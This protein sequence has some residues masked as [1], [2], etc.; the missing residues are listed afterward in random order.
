MMISMIKRINIIYFLIGLA[1]LITNLCFIDIASAQPI[2]KVAVL[3]IQDLT[4]GANG[5]N[6]NCTNMLEQDLSNHGIKTVS[7]KQIMSFLVRHRIRWTGYIDSYDAFMLGKELNTNYVLLGTICQYDNKIEPK[8]G[9]TLVLL[10]TK[11][12]S[13]VWAWVGSLSIKD[14]IHPLGLFE[15]K[16]AANILPFLIDKA[17]RAFPETIEVKG[18]IFPCCSIKNVIIRPR[19]V[20]SGELVTCVVRVNRLN[21]TIKPIIKLYLNNNYIKFR[22]IYRNEYKA[23]FKAPIKQGS[24][25]V[26]LTYQVKKHLHK[27]YVG[28]IVVDN[29]APKVK[30]IARGVHIW[31]AIALK[32]RL[33]ILPR[34]TNPEPI[35][36]WQIAVCT[37]DGEKILSQDGP[38]PL[39][40]RF[41][42][43]GQ[44]ASGA[45]V[46]TGV[47]KIV[48]DIWDMAGNKAQATIKVAVIRT[49]PQIKVSSKFIHNKLILTVT[50]DTDIP[51]SFWRLEIFEGNDLLYTDIGSKLP[52]TISLSIPKKKS[53]R[54]FCIV[55][56]RDIFGNITKKKFKTTIVITHGKKV[57]KKKNNNSWTPT[58]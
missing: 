15:P 37:L 45:M 38:G 24:F 46:A 4:H 14:F 50:N 7:N 30:L 29:Q 16:N 18:K 6:F 40:S 53:A 48:L 41:F 9:L 57:S 8:V 42:W 36:R 22:H 49:P 17:V 31:N 1:Y 52:A 13:S 20:K 32:K 26:Y 11:T 28:N 44:D 5:V 47:Y 10:D 2:N 51:L 19:F 43:N 34:L 25:P 12:A 33:I 27:L 3:P 35:S 58:F 54:L 23:I 56:A 39:P 55:T 21:N